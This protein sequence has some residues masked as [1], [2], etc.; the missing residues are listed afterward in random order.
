MPGIPPSRRD[1]PVMQAIESATG[2]AAFF[3]GIHLGWDANPPSGHTPFLRRGGY[4]SDRLTDKYTAYFGLASSC[5]RWLAATCRQS[6]AAWERSP[7]KP[8]NLNTACILSSLAPQFP[9]FFPLAVQ[10]YPG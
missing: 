3:C 8:Q 5:R 1:A 4:G 10:R 7:A 9:P 2:T 6:N